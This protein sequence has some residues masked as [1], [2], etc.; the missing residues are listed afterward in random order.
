VAQK[1]PSAAEIAEEKMPGWKVIEPSGPIKRF[2]SLPRDREAAD[3]SATTAVQSPE[4]DAVMPSTSQLRRKFLGN[5]AA[6]TAD[7]GTSELLAPDVEVLD[8]K[9]GDLERTVGVNR[10]TGKI[11]WSQ[12]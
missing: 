6:G 2:G 11:E 8:M 12:G 9:S 5:D 7:E 10:R 3:Y 1:K 4:V